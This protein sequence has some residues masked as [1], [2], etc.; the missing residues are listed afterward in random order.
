M[1]ASKQL[2]STPLSDTQIYQ[3]A[4]KVKKMKTDSEQK[5]ILKNNAAYQ[6]EVKNDPI[7]KAQVKKADLDDSIVERGRM[8]A[9][10]K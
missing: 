10:A 7:L 2:M 1:E 4:L 9:Q 6:A 3:K 8:L 5:Q